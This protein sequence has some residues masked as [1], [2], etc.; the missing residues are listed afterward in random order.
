MRFGESNLNLSLKRR[1]NKI[2]LNEVAINS[3]PSTFLDVEGFFILL[4]KK[5]LWC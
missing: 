2:L 3:K 5:A 4:Q 1:G